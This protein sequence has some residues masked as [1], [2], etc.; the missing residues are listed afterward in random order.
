MKALP[1]IPDKSVDLILTDLPYGT[2]QAKW[3]S[4]IPI[5]ELWDQF[6]RVITFNGVIALFATQQFAI[7]LM[8]ANIDNYKYEW[9]WFKQTFGDFVHAKNK[10]INRH[11]HILIFS[12][13]GMGHKSLL[14]DKRMTYNPQGIKKIKKP[15]TMANNFKGDVM[16]KRP[17]HETPY[18]QEYEN[19]PITVLDYPSDKKRYHPTQKPNELLKFFIRSYT[20]A[21]DT[22]LDATMGSGS[23]GV[24]CV[25]TDRKFIGFETNEDYFNIAKERIESAK[26]D[27]R[28]GQVL[29]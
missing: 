18:T 12:Q 25:N 4:I 17:S 27:V 22:V 5:D 26:P 11:E 16:G 7:K 15:K 24:A 14:K 6:N 20:D 23:T 21:Q 8:N 19:Y 13:S 29:F 28:K 1:K 3:D 10:P 2:I 9:I